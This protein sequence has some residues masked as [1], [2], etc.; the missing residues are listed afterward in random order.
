[1]P[2]IV[3]V[4]EFSRTA[5]E[6]RWFYSEDC[7]LAASWPDRFLDAVLK[8][9]TPGEDAAESVLLLTVVGGGADVAL[10]TSARVDHAEGLSEGDLGLIVTH[11]S[12]IVKT[13]RRNLGRRLRERDGVDTSAVSDDS[14]DLTRVVGMST[15]M[16]RNADKLMRRN[17]LVKPVPHISCKSFPVAIAAVDALCDLVVGDLLVRVPG[18]LV[19]SV[20]NVLRGQR[21]RDKVDVFRRD[22][23]VSSCKLLVP[24]LNVGEELVLDGV[25]RLRVEDRLRAIEESKNGITVLDVSLTSRDGE[26]LVSLELRIANECLQLALIFT[27]ISA[28]EDPDVSLHLRP[29]LALVCSHFKFNFT[30]V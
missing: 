3:I 5:S 14:I 8:E 27:R 6:P 19:T 2:K 13:A 12:H 24:A 16:E 22:E 18:G 1:M 25:E 9:S 17:E 30:T 20:A 28:R 11:D 4:Q 10:L 21:Q 7:A 23:L 26:N 15:L 29:G